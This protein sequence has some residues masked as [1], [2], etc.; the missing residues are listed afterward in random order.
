MFVVV[1]TIC[2]VLGLEVKFVRDRKTYVALIKEA[3]KDRSSGWALP[4]PES[5]VPNGPDHLPEWREPRP[6]PTIPFWRKWLGDEPFGLI[7]V[8]GTWSESEVS[9]IKAR[10]PEAFV[11]QNIKLPPKAP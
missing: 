9:K 2:L 1:T 5:E 10:F 4:Y 6:T 7:A 11:F 3:G 8:P